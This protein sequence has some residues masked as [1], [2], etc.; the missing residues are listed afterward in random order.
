MHNGSS[1]VHSSN[2]QTTYTVA[3]GTRAQVVFEQGFSPVVKQG[4]ERSQV[5][6]KLVTSLKLGGQ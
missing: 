1:K 4:G 5:F 3:S 6:G 2:E